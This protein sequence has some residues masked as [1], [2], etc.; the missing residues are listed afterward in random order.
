MPVLRLVIRLRLIFINWDSQVQIFTED[1]GV[2][3]KFENILPSLFLSQVPIVMQC[4]FVHVLE[5]LF[6][7]TAPVISIRSKHYGLYQ[8]HSG[9]WN[10]ISVWGEQD[11][12]KLTFHQPW[13]CEVGL[14]SAQLSWRRVPELLCTSSQRWYACEQPANER[15]LLP[16][17][18]QH[19]HQ[20]PQIYTKRATAHHKFFGAPYRISKAQ[21]MV[22][23][24]DFLLKGRLGVLGVGYELA[25]WLVSR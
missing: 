1:W 25:W 17:A 2:F 12:R 22:F 18:S 10:L 21:M 23:D 4:R 8:S 13:P 20:H 14:N 6:A 3:V 5:E 24:G 9:D 15:Y 16:K 7:V 11:D 19:Q